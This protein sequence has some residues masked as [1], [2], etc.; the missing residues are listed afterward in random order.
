MKDLDYYKK[1]AEE[2]YRTTPISVLRYI[3][4]LE[5]SAPSELLERYNESVEALNKIV[6]ELD[7][8]AQP[9]EWESYDELKQVINKHKEG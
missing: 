3:T 5:G 4:E 8:C 9:S 2:D 7:D 6:F 1:N